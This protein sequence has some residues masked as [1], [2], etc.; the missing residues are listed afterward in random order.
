MCTLRRVF[1][2]IDDPNNDLDT[3]D[4]FVNAHLIPML[5]LPRSLGDLR[6]GFGAPYLLSPP[7]VI[8]PSGSTSSQFVLHGQPGLVGLPLVIQGV[9]LQAGRIGI[10]NALDFTI[11]S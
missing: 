4:S 8:G 9:V 7:T 11:G 6:A 3:R 5:G 1:D 2:E 10:A